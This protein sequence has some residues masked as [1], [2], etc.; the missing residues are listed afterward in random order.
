M[1]LSAIF[2]GVKLVQR[3][4]VCTSVLLLS[5]LP[6]A[7]QSS[8]LN[9]K[10]A[11][12][13]SI[14]TTLVDAV[15]PGAA[16]LVVQD[17]KVVHQKGYGLANVE[18]K[19]PIT[20][21]STFDLAS[22]SKQFTA[23][24]IMMLAERGKLAYDDPL[25]KFFPEFPAYAARITVRHLLNHTSGLPDYMGV[26]RGRPAGISSEP[27][28]R[29]AV[30]M[31]AQIP[32]PL[33]APGE[34]YQYSNSGYVVLGQ[35]VEKAS[36]TTF[37]AFLKT[38]VFDPLGMSTTIVSDQIMAP[39]KNR[40]VSYRP[41]GSGFSNADYTPLNR[42]YGD[43]NVNTSVEDMYKW[44]QALYTDRLVKQSTLAEAFTSTKLNNGALSDY[45][46]GWGIETWLGRRAVSHGGAWAG[47]RTYIMRFP[48]ERFS[49]IVLSNAANFNPGAAAR[50]IAGVYL[51]DK[52]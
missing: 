1:I 2:S 9:Q 33:F 28:S 7:A 10:S 45:G 25:T 13:D 29:E 18:T 21:T 41:A 27:T 16:V 42:I 19:S 15:A 36:G 44:D 46:F 43:G 14:M 51:G 22:V 40:A 5:A 12:V 8:Q 35:I 4:L 31:L 30:T 6:V 38:N 47:F 39:S 50:R 11:R 17:G 49:I 34:K 52:T 3:L 20:T 24:A 48:E 23:M 26:F 37:P 32:E